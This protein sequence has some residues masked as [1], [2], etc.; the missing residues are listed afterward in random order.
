MPYI[1]MDEEDYWEVPERLRIMQELRRDRGR[2]KQ[3][4]LGDP[5]DDSAAAGIISEFPPLFPFLRH[6][7]DCYAFTLVLKG[8][9]FVEEGKVLYPG[10]GMTAGPH[11]LYGPDLSGPDGCTVVE[12][13]G[14]LTG[15]LRGIFEMKNGG[16]F[17]VNALES[18]PS[19]ESLPAAEALAGMEKLEKLRVAALAA[20][21]ARKDP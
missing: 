13:F 16:V 18:L 8:S 14:R 19:A 17:S 6:A 9:L 3:F 1:K 5:E 20:G 11:E 21:S 10:D 4:V 12:F 15:L 7:H 2:S